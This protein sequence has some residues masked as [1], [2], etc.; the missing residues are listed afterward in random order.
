[1]G[2]REWYHNEIA[3]FDS[4]NIGPDCFDYADGFVS[5]DASRVAVF[6]CFVRP[7]IAAAD[8]GAGHRD[9]RVSWL[10]DASVGDVFD[11]NVAGA[12]HNSCT[13]GDSL[14]FPISGYLLLTC[15][16]SLRS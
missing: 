5:H 13:H 6:H 11:T 2:E 9:Y 3:G 14:C 10:D 1:M 16:F 12:E 4:A 8:A 7:E 15:Y